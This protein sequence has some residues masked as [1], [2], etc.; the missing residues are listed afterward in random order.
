MGPAITK[1]RCCF[2][3]LFTTNTWRDYRGD[4]PGD[5]PSLPIKR[6]R[7]QALHEQRKL[8]KDGVSLKHMPRTNRATY[9]PV[10]S[11]L[12]TQIVGLSVL[13][14]LSVLTILPA[15][16]AR[17]VVLVPWVPVRMVLSQSSTLAEVRFGG[18]DR[19]TPSGNHSGCGRRDGCGCWLA[20]SA[21]EPAGLGDAYAPRGQQVRGN[22]T[23]NTRRGDT[24][25]SRGGKGH[26]CTRSFRARETREQYRMYV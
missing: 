5:V 20:G 16:L 23:H 26:V 8:K 19:R 6:L 11:I 24:E 10:L 18:G 12:F 22:F 3:P 15:T 21:P 2:E 25:Q 17:F 4:V 7:N 14:R 9:D 1:G 13:T